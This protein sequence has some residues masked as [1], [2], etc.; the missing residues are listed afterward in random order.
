MILCIVKYTSFY[1]TFHKVH[2]Q[3]FASILKI[4]ITF[5][6]FHAEGWNLVGTNQRHNSKNVY[7]RFLRYF[8]PGPVRAM[9]LAHWTIFFFCKMLLNGVR[10]ILGLVK[11][12]FL[13]KITL[14]WY[15]QKILMVKCK[16]SY[17]D[18]TMYR[19]PACSHVIFCINTVGLRKH[20]N[21]YDDILVIR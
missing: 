2:K 12:C 13:P 5:W 19:C 8:A 4:E 7:T 16:K 18:K 14:M 9:A 15:F 21:K 17:T 6:L 20:C 3:L 1:T 10:M 11:S